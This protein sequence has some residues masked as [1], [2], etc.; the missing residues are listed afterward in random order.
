[1][2]KLMEDELVKSAHDVSL[3]GIITAISKMAIKVI[4]ALGYWST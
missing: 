4:Y 2:Q 3:G 1:M